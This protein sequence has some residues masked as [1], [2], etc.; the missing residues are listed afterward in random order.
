MKLALFFAVFLL[1][2]C[3]SASIVSFSYGSTSLGISYIVVGIFPLMLF[4]YCVYMMNGEKGIGLPTEDDLDDEV[5]YE[6]VGENISGKPILLKN[7]S[8][9]KV[10]LYK[11]TCAPAPVFQ[12]KSAKNFSQMK[13]AIE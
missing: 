6:V 11:L 2:C 7:D 8:T 9:G 1:I 12:G 3:V 13:K 4:G 10:L 5:T